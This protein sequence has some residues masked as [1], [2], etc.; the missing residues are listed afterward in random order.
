MKLFLAVIWLGL[1]DILLKIPKQKQA[2]YK[3]EQ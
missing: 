3:I 1:N 2:D